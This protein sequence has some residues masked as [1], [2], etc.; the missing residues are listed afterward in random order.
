MR[1]LI[2][3]ALLTATC[4]ACAD[5]PAPSDPT[6]AG[7]KWLTARPENAHPYADDTLARFRKL[8]EG[9]GWRDAAW[10]AQG[11]FEAVH[12]KTELA[13]V[14]IPGGPFMM[15][16]PK[17]ERREYV[18]DEQLP[19]YEEQH[20]VTV[21]P[22]L[23]SKTEC[24]QM[25][26]VRG[27][28]TN[29]LGSKGGSLPVDSVTWDACH[30]WCTDSGL[31][32][33]SEAEWEYAC[34]AGSTGRWCFGDAEAKLTEFGWYFIN[35]GSRTLPAG[36]DRDFDAID[37]AWGCRPHEVGQKKPNPWGL[38]DTHGN[39]LEW[40]EDWFWDRYIGTEAPWRCSASTKPLGPARHAW[41]RV[42]VLR[43]RVAR[44]LRSRAY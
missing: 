12:E 36:T 5:G 8:V 31:R 6:P 42:G 1:T 10:N 29:P 30:A 15:G 2:V 22:F 25:A 9:N 32:L 7:P 34:R 13:F 20:R 24:T 17:A 18:G 23:L 11:T 3:F 14:L 38:L 4:A 28:G 44:L 35:S 27:G 40:C 19:G 39:V 26:W 16:A 41:K 33:P 37:G 43:R 21:P